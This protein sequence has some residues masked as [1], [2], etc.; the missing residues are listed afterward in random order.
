MHI[1][2]IH[3]AVYQ[4]RVPIDRTGAA[5]L[6]LVCGERTALIDTGAADS[7]GSAL[8]PTLAVLGRSF[9]DIRLILNTHAH[10]DHAGGNAETSRRS[11]APVHLHALELPLARST[12]AQ[13]E[14]HIGPLRALDFPPDA[15]QER[16]DHLRRM[17]GETAD[18]AAVLGD[19]DRLELGGGVVLTAVHCP[20]HSPGHLAYLWEAEGLLFCGDAV[21]GQG[22][23]AGGYP[24]YLDAASY[25]RSLQRLAALESR[26]LCLGHAYHGGALINTPTREA[27]EARA[28]LETSMAVADTIH[29]TVAAVMRRLPIASKREVA[30]AALADLVY[31]IPQLRLRRTD[32]PLLAAPTLLAHMEAVRTGSYPTL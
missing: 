14:S 26:L 2:R 23:W 1:E 27:G 5:Y 22:A 3:Q 6:Y 31:E 18:A 21:Q 13:I 30:C 7:P 9:G 16:A 17:A 32:M 11:G 20:G 8:A 10:L 25:R 19:G 15:I 12:E 28:L 24:S 4:I 29:R